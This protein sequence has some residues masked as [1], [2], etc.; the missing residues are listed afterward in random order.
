MS[1]TPQDHIAQCRAMSD[2]IRKEFE[3]NCRLGDSSETRKDRLL[4]LASVLQNMSAGTK[5]AG[6][7]G[8]VIQE[9]LWREMLDDM[10]VGF[11]DKPMDGQGTAEADYYFRGYALSHKT[12]GYN[13][14]NSVNLA[15]AWSKNP[16]GGIQRTNFTSSMV[17]LNF[18]PQPST[19]TKDINWRNA[20][21]GIH[22]IPLPNLAEIVKEFGSNNKTDSLISPKYVGEL[23]AFSQLNNFSIYFNFDYSLGKNYFLSYWRNGIKGAVKKLG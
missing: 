6:L 15:L 23:I 4:F 22:I 5:G 13:S 12:I 2:T 8:G 11:S 20:K 18:K 1:Q 10:N 21:Q 16:E 7:S 3:L 17:I 14:S 19:R 9:N